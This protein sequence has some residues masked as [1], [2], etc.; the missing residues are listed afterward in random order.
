MRICYFG[1]YDP[2]YPRNRVI[3][4]GLRKVGVDLAE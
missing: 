4:K 3:L 1:C 2:D